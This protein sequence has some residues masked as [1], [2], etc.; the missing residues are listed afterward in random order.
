[1]L[2]PQT[3]IEH[4]GGGGWTVVDSPNVGSQ[5]NVLYGVACTNAQDCWA[6]G[7]RAST[8]GNQRLIEHYTATMWSVD[9]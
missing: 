7:A 2:V 1:M 8:I 9:G 6:V 3:L 4:Y 5:D